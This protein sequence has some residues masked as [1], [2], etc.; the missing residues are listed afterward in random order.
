MLKHIHKKSLT[1]EGSFFSVLVSPLLVDLKQALEMTTS[2]TLGTM[3]QLQSSL[4][5]ISHSHQDLCPGEH[6]SL[7]DLIEMEYSIHINLNLPLHTTTNRICYHQVKIQ[8]TAGHV[9]ICTCTVLVQ[10]TEMSSMNI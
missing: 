3:G 6:A 9:L 1:F 2:V 10:C 7:G 5:P 4:Q 8:C